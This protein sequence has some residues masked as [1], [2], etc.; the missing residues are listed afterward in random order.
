MK[1]RYKLPFFNWLAQLFQKVSGIPPLTLPRAVAGGLKEVTA[2][3]GCARNGIPSEYTEVIYVERPSG[4]TEQC[5][6][7]SWKPNLAKNI[8]VYGRAAYLGDVTS[9]RPILL[10]N[11]TGT[12]SSTLNIEF[13]GRTANN[14][15]V[16]TLKA[17]AALGAD[18]QVG[19][20]ALNDIVDF[21]LEITGATGTLAVTASANGTTV[22]GSGTVENIGEQ[23]LYNMMLFKDHRA[24]TISASKV[25]VRIYYLKVTEDG[26]E[27]LDLVPV[28]RNSDA[29]VGFFD[30]VSKT[31]LFNSGTG[32]LVAGDA[33]TPSP[34]KPVLLVCNNGVIKRHTD[35]E[36]WSLQNG[37]PAPTSPIDIENYHQKDMVLHGI[38]T[39]KDTYNALTNT[40]TRKVGVK[41]FNGSETEFLTSSA[42]PCYS[43]PKTALGTNSTVLPASTGAELLLCTHYPCS[44]SSVDE[45]CWSGNYNVNFNSITRFETL[46]D[47]KQ[48]L[49]QQYQNGTPVTLYYPLATETQETWLGD[50]WWVD[51]TQET[52]TVDNSSAN[53]EYLL[54]TTTTELNFIDTQ[55]ILKG[56]TTRNV[57]IKVFDGTE[58]ITVAGNTTIR[59]LL[60]TTS[61]ISGCYS[62]PAS[63]LM[64]SHFLSKYNLAEVGCSYRYLRYFYFTYYPDTTAADFKQFLADQY[65]AGTPV[66]VVYPLATPVTEQI[67][68]QALNTVAG[69]NTL[70]IAQ[71]SLPGLELSAEY[72]RH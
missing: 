9:Y 20:F 16:Y 10:G 4:N 23:T 8:A 18:L 59:S 1:L 62:G 34:D 47:F 42:P 58:N 21:S 35:A 45:V 29:L 61:Q 6:D 57:G 60:R 46:D 3:G 53:A 71:A 48:F 64:C 15:R 7:T 54:K 27:V 22:T 2:Y 41:I 13:D 50:N 40:I 70:E 72:K 12:R 56:L 43:Y 31:F 17:N 33:V 28:K 11:Y 37:T 51:G 65:A 24:T 5:I 55:D 44:N 66:I 63:G 69:T 19:P 68:P 25:P 49:A 26:R 38:S 36:G 30:R 14:F 52:I 39:Y 67:T 32:S